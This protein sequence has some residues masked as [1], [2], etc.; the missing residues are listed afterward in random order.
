[1]KTITFTASQDTVDDDGESVKLA[2]D[3]PPTRVRV[4][5]T[6][7]TTVS[8]DD[9]DGAGVS[10]SKAALTI[11]EGRSGTYT[12]VLDSQPTANVA[13]AINDPPGNT[14]VTADPA[15]P[16]VL[17]ERLELGEDGDG[18]SRAG[19]R[20]GRRDGHR[21][22]HRDLHRHQLQQRHG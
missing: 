14:D 13:V 7:T 17:L 19:R 20:R 8:I 22:P 2:F 11:G 1:M 10:V 21:D 6:A 3:T 16:D 18:G 15:E 9:D 12:I 4:G 5:T